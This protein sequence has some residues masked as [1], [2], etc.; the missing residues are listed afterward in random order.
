TSISYALQHAD[1]PIGTR[2]H[3]FETRFAIAC[4][5]RVGKIH[6]RTSIAPFDRGV[7]GIEKALQIL[8]QP[9]IA[10][11]LAPLLVHALLHDAPASVCGDDEGV[12]IQIEAVLYGRAVDLRDETARVHERRGVQAGAFA[13]RQELCGCLARMRA[14]A[15]AHV[16]AELP[17]ERREPSL[18][19]PHDARRNAGRMPIHAHDGAEGLKPERMCEATQHLVATVMKRDRLDDYASETCHASTEP[20]RNT[21]A[22][23]REIG[24]SGSSRHVGLN[25]GVWP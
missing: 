12:Q 7:R 25:R 2:L 15:A 10:P 4:R 3:E 20:L 19:R 11:R 5:A 18:E 9:V 6:D 14:L 16:N 23:E 21:S 24:T 1:R 8:R 17:L 22:V 13:D